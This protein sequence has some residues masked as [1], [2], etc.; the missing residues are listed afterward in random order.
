MGCERV[1]LVGG[2]NLNNVINAY[3]AVPIADSEREPQELL[4]TIVESSRQKD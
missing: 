1:V 4:N 3:D 2:Y